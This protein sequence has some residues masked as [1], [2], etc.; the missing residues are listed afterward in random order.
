MSWVEDVAKIVAVVS[1][2]AGLFYW[3]LAWIDKANL[4]TS[5]ANNLMLDSSGREHHQDLLLS[6]LSGLITKIS[7]THYDTVLGRE[8]SI[9]GGRYYAVFI[10]IHLYLILR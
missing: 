8:V 7:Y 6:H 3:E 1:G 2:G 5:C 4:A 9:V 10:P